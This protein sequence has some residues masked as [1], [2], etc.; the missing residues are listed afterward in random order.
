MMR[1]ALAELARKPEEGDENYEQKIADYVERPQIDKIINQLR[2]NI[3]L[4]FTNKD[5]T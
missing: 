2:G 1:A 5:L 4:I 3:S